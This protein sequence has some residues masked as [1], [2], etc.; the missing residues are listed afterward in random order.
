[1]A[2]LSN[3]TD[4]DQPRE[5][6]KKHTDGDENEKTC[7]LVNMAWNELSRRWTLPIIHELGR[8]EVIRFNEL[9]RYLSDISS[10]SLS[11]RLS[12]LEKM[13]IVR[14]RIYPEIPPRVEYSLTVK[15]KELHSILAELASWVKKW[16][17]EPQ[18][19]PPMVVSA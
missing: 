8:H 4:F 12:D 15:G 16:E 18:K 6:K 2:R 19:M 5:T 13:G 17:Y 10:T 9:K 11:E 7:T 14:R 1:L 3:Q